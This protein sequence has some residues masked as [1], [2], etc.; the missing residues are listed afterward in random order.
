MSEAAKSGGEKSGGEKSGGEKSEGKGPEEEKSGEGKPGGEVI[1]LIRKK[2]SCPNCGQ[3]A[4]A[5]F[6]P[7]CSKRCADLD[8]GRWLKGSYR[9][10]GETAPSDAEEEERGES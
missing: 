7:F 4:V 9:I 3:P 8:L 5:R 10:P 2:R 6:R 1:P